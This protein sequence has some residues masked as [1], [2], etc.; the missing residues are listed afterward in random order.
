MTKILNINPNKQYTISWDCKK[1]DGNGTSGFNFIYSDGTEQYSVNQG[2]NKLTSISGK[3]ISK[4]GITYSTLGT[5]DL[6]NIQIE[7][8]DTATEYE[9]YTYNDITI[10]INEPLRK[11]DIIRAENRKILVERHMGEVVFD[12]S[13]DEYWISAAPAA[14]VEGYTTRYKALSNFSASSSTQIICN[15]LTELNYLSSK[16]DGI[17]Y[18]STYHG[19]SITVRLNNAK[20]NSYDTLGFKQ[21]LSENPLTIQYQLA[22][23]VIEEVETDYTRLMLESYENATVHFNSH[24]F[25]TSTIRYQANVISTSEIM[26]VSDQQDAMIIDN[27]TQIAMITLTM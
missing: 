1:I 11:G 12:G 3:T 14:I 9:P 23:P 6:T 20:L 4:I 7:Q 26:S 17:F 8:G 25:P 24:I 13:D 27:A 19:N 15:K 5:S 21:W 2:H 10:Y 18:T 22:S 16:N